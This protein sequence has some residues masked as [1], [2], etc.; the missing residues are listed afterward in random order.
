MQSINMTKTIQS[1]SVASLTKNGN[2]VNIR[3]GNNEKKIKY[4][5]LIIKITGLIIIYVLLAFIFILIFGLHSMNTTIIKPAIKFGINKVKNDI[6]F[7]AK[8]LSTEYGQLSLLDGDLVGQ[9]G[10]SLKNNHKLVDAI[11]SDYA[12]VAT[13]FARNGNDYRRISTSIVDNAGKRAVDTFLETDNAAYQYIKDGYSYT[14]KEV[15]LGKNYITRYRPIFTENGK[16]VI[17]ILSIGFETMAIEK[18]I[19]T[20]IVKYVIKRTVIMCIILLVFLS[21]SGLG[22]KFL[23]RRVK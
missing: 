7:F 4:R 1:R 10:V 16:E 18:V 8:R 14:G 22:Y 12:I 15:I 11:S 17:G 21:L 6:V 5:S 23:S 20:N 9:E 19:K 3:T 13:V 2:E